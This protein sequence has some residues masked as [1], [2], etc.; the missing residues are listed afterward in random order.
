MSH[1]VTNFESEVIARSEEVPVLVDFWAA[2]CGPC[3]MLSPTLDKLAAEAGGRWELAKVNTDE[4][5]DLAQRFEIQG[6]PNLKLFHHGEVIAELAGAL[7][8]PQL[9]EWLTQN[10]PTPKRQ[11]MAQARELLHAG[12]A[13]EAA[14][15]LEPL[16][17]A[18][19]SDEELAVLAGRALV[20]AKPSVAR[21]L[22]G[23]V[24]AGSPWSEGA[25]NVEALA[26]VLA[27]PAAAANASSPLA[28]PYRQALQA[29]RAQD[30]H[31]AAAGLVAVLTENPGFDDGR[32]KAAC[33]ALF[34]HLGIRHPISEEFSRAFSM[35]VNV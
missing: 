29:L 11:T 7:P 33:R 30:F 8:E 25:R 26:A 10:L 3:K 13:A 4:N 28:E 18:D 34:Q 20:F 23:R 24:A 19:P 17:A 14:R 15:L 12:R 27:G 9:R 6:I 2:W 35:A 31:A 16:V 5:P 22:V 21:T 32:A 1:D